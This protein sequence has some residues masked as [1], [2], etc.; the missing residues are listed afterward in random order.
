[1]GYESSSHREYLIKNRSSITDLV[2]RASI[3]HNKNMSWQ[4]TSPGRFERPLD[5]LEI[6]FKTIA[7]G[8]A[9][10]NKEHWAVRV[11]AQFRSTLP[12]DS[13]ESALRQ[14]WKTMR[15]DHPQLA[16]FAKGDK[17]VYEVPT[18]VALDSW[19]AKTFH[20][21]PAMT[22]DDL[23]A[24]FE[25]SSLP[26]IHYLPHTSEIL[27]RASHW[28]IDGIGALQLLNNFFKALG[29]PRQIKFGDEGRNLS[30]S[31]D[32]IANFP[33]STTDEKD[34][35][36]IR[37]LKK[38]TSNTPSIGLPTELS[39]QVP[40][41]T[42]R[43]E[44]TFT[45]P[46]TSAIISACKARTL[47]VAT[48]LHSALIVA[49]KQLAYSETLARN[50]TSWGT[51]DLRPYLRSPYSKPHTH[52]V[53][54]YVI[55]LPISLAPSDFS[56]NT[57]QLRPFYKQLSSQSANTPLP[58]FFRSYAKKVTELFSHPP[59]PDTQAPTEPGLESLGVVDC[60]V[61]REHGDGVE[62]ER[63]WVGVEML[64]RQICLYVWTWQDCMTLSVCYNERFY[65][66]DF[67]S[68]F[69][70]RVKGILFVELSVDSA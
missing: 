16:A 68:G 31:L 20:V 33:A 3:C 32:E 11:C 38:Y 29:K 41:A 52:P 23:L 25:P 6:F 58:S 21:A 37:L 17:K 26:T 59:P 44:L 65:T 66:A 56:E 24:T 28:C 7:D 53:S 18:S 39:N 62:I 8:S 60:Y 50:Y 70:A 36:A 61:D 2:Y 64:T 34:E 54:V 5:T 57:S 10:L 19:L 35:A 43:I 12:A 47:S 48:A 1:M 40:G 46:I 4:E 9:P 22:A 15:Y 51:F 49:T 45:P 63:F 55:G 27:I 13:V 69:L 30:P 67:V 14:A 42:R